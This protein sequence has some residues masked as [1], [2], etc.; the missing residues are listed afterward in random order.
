[1]IFFIWGLFFF[2]ISVNEVNGV[3]STAKNIAFV[4]IE[5]T[6]LK[7]EKTGTNGL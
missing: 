3:N 1:M 2:F 5:E 4:E 7:T 6:S